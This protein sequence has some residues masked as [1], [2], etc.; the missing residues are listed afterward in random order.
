MVA[1]SPRWSSA[2]LRTRLE[3]DTDAADATAADDDDT[4]AANPATPPD[5]GASAASCGEEPP[6][7]PSPGG[8]SGRGK[9]VGGR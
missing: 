4:D 2:S 1:P 5:W 8:R 7:A 9:A 3:P 6:Q